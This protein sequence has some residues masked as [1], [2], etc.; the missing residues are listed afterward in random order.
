MVVKTKAINP[1]SKS[2]T[3]GLVYDLSA[4]ALAFASN[5]FAGVISMMMSTY[6]PASVQDLLGSVSTNQVS[7]VGSYINALFLLGWAFGGFLLGWLGDRWGRVRIFSTSILVFSMFT[8]AVFWVSSWYMLVVFRF[9]AG[10]GIGATMVLSAVLVAEIWGERAKGRAIALSVM[11]VGF[12][13]GIIASGMISYLL[14]DWRSAFLVGF[15]PL[16]LAVV[17][18]FFFEEPQ[19]WSHYAQEKTYNGQW[20]AFKKLSAPE[21]RKNF[22]IGTTIFGAMLIGLWAVFSWLPTWAQSLVGTA[23]AGEQEGGILLML[24]GMGGI[25]GCVIAGFLANIMGRRR[26]LLLSFAGAFVCTSLLFWTNHTFGFVIYLETAVLSLFFGISQGI[27]TVYIPELFPTSIR[28]TATGI[29]F[30]AGRLFTAAAV[31]FVGILVP[32]LGG[33]GN[34]LF[35]FSLTYAIGFLVTWFGKETKGSTL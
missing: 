14:P 23:K 29:G 15:L 26:A 19:Q 6:L 8:L 34:A 5:F 13:I 7:Y 12:P 33:Y 28:S 35:V 3:T 4:V 11:S 24:L 1:K 32:I 16:L 9:L 20:S 18:Q 30:N 27:L 10:L 21:N 2:L 25:V 31:F 17:C 22:V